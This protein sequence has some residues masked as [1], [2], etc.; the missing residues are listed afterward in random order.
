MFFSLKVCVN[1]KCLGF[2]FISHPEHNITGFSIICHGMR[3]VLKYERWVKYAMAKKWNFCS[4]S[5]N[6][7]DDESILYCHP[8]DHKS[9]Q[10]S[11]YCQWRAVFRCCFVVFPSLNQYV[12]FCRLNSHNSI[13]K[14]N[15]LRWLDNVTLKFILKILMTLDDNA[16]YILLSNIC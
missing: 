1:A 15:L 4:G 13:Q 6:V 11:H 12:Q 10:W 8:S 5:K 2:L 3:N 9:R 16:A 14:K 7:T